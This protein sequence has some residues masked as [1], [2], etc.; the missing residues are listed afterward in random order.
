MSF[1]EMTLSFRQ[2]IT[3]KTCG[4]FSISKTA[5]SR[6]FA[7][8]ILMISNV[9]IVRN[10]ANET[11]PCQGEFDQ[12]ICCHHTSVRGLACNYLYNVALISEGRRKERRVDYC[13]GV[14]LSSDKCCRRKRSER[15]CSWEVVLDENDIKCELQLH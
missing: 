14:L 15:G 5:N 9:Y 12:S 1:H 11:L 3:V 13:G 2:V 7:E 10:F 4:P 8:M 6:I